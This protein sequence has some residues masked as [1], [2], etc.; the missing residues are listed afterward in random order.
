MGTSAKTLSRITTL[1]GEGLL[2]FGA[3]IIELGAQELYCTGQDAFVR[4]V[5]RYFSDRNP[6]I[7][8]A[9]DYSDA[10][11][12][13]LANRGML[14]RTLKACGF[15]YRALD[16]FD[17]E[18]TTL[19][20]LNLQDPGEDLTGK[21]D[22]VTNFGTT[23]HVINQYRSMKTMHELAKPGGLIYHDLPFS[24]YHNHGYFCYNPLLFRHLA[25]ANGYRIVMQHYS[26]AAVPTKA[27][28][29]MTE[30]GYS[31]PHYF[32]AGIEFIFQ[33]TSAAPFRMPLET[34][35]SLDVNS[36]LWGDENPYT[37]NAVSS[38]LGKDFEAFVPADITEIPGRFLRRELVR[39]TRLKLASLFGRK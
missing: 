24:G 35:T 36:A 7:R 29:F 25:D 28:A 18:D 20:D 14:T 5:I 32:D 17:A 26:K 11:I 15:S 10:E 38:K 34:S 1:H 19:F 30:N 16:I 37:A 4:D 23:E 3:S 6:S 9:D 8:K 27:P 39:R 22:L 12:A 21:F 33:K 31:D 2:P 13:A